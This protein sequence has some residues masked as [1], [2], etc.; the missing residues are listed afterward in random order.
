MK[1]TILTC[2]TRFLCLLVI[3]FIAASAQRA[4]AK[5]VDI[6]TEVT[7]G[8]DAAIQ[9]QIATYLA[10][11]TERALVFLDNGGYRGDPVYQLA[12]RFVGRHRIANVST[13]PAAQRTE[14]RGVEDP[15]DKGALFADFNLTGAYAFTLSVKNKDKDKFKRVKAWSVKFPREKQNERVRIGSNLIG[16]DG[17]VKI[18]KEQFDRLANAQFSA[19]AQRRLRGGVIDIPTSLWFPHRVLRAT[20]KGNQAR[21]AIQVKNTTPLRVHQIE[22]DIQIHSDDTVILKN[23][24]NSTRSRTIHGNARGAANGID[25]GDSKT[26]NIDTTISF[27][28]KKTLYRVVQRGPLK[29]TAKVKRVYWGGES[30]IETP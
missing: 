15:K 2:T 7:I 28:E 8:V 24:N 26:F 29:F 23:S 13:K 11:E 30:T 6:K 14:L 1:K 25:S 20:A 19:W 22:F 12:I 5:V 21:L 18:K 3:L 9:N 16:A 10:K 17:K 4:H 27:M